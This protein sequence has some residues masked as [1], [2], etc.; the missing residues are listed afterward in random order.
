MYGNEIR[1]ASFLDL[2]W[3]DNF[4]EIPAKTLQRLIKN[5]DN[6]DW[7]G[8]RTEDQSSD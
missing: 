7:Q 4:V 2:M 8:R 6:V 5:P 3:T 1:R